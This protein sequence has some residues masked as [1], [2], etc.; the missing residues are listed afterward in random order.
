MMFSTAT[1]AEIQIF[2][3]EDEDSIFEMSRENV[4]LSSTTTYFPNVHVHSN[5]V[6]ACS[7]TEG[8]REVRPTTKKQ[9][10]TEDSL[11]RQAD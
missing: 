10:K 6:K 5:V 11:S 2:S 4:C 1:S 8:W 9:K 3:Y 7:N